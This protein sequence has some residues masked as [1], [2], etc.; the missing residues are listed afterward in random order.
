MASALKRTQQKDGTWSMGILGGVTG[1]P[2]KETSGASFFIFGLAWGINQGLLDRETY[3]PVILKGWNALSRCVTDEG[4]L[5]HVQPVGA[6]P[7]DSFA[8][9]TEVYGIGAFLA[10]GAEM[11]KLLSH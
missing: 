5:G 9:K 3:E 10:A 11:Y 7:G 1:Y 8:D 2:V 6:A 4:I